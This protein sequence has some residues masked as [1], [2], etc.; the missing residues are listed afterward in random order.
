IRITIGTSYE[1]EKF[2]TEF[3]KILR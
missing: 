1:N 2:F 3:D